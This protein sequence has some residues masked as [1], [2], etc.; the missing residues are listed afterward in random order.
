M[1]GNTVLYLLLKNDNWKDYADI[2][3][4]K[5]LKIYLQSSDNTKPID[6]ILKIDLDQFYQIV[7]DSYIFQLKNHH[8][9][10]KDKFD[11]NALIVLNSN[12]EIEIANLKQLILQRI[13]QGISYPATEMDYHIKLINPPIVNFTHYNARTIDGIFYLLFLLRKYPELKIPII[14]DKDSIDNEFKKIDSFTTYNESYE[15][16][17]NHLKSFWKFNLTIKDK[18]IRNIIKWDIYKTCFLS[19]QLAG[20]FIYWHDPDNYY[21]SPLLINSINNTIK[22]Y[23]NTK[24]IVIWLTIV[25]STFDHANIIIYD[26]NRKLFEAF[27]PHQD[28]RPTAPGMDVYLDKLFTSSFNNNDNGNNNGNKIKYYPAGK[29][30]PRNS[31]QVYDEVSRTMKISVLNDPIGFC[32]AWCIWYLQMRII[33]YNI[34]PKILAQISLYKIS[35]IPD[36]SFTDYIRNYSE[37]I[38]QEKLNI[39]KE[40][41]FPEKYWYYDDYLSIKTSIIEPMIRK[42]KKMWDEVVLV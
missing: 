6:F 30:I 11:T 26:I 7:I 3:K 23:P 34:N 4:Q 27:D 2:L 18:S 1:S 37:M 24:L 9:K 35:T 38:T 17:E 25:G 28:G 39:L 16:N 31:F 22:K 41:S 10:F 8:K 42:F 36:Q 33:N 12:D 5:K 13:T 32:L 15:Y 29:I 19:Y 21:V 20:S 14:P 40:L